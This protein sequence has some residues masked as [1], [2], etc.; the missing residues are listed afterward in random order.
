[1]PLNE[2]ASALEADE[3]LLRLQAGVVLDDE[4]DEPRYTTKSP[5]SNSA[6]QHKSVDYT[7]A[8]DATQLYLNEVGF[9]ALLTPQEEV[10]FA[11]LTQRGDP[12]AR[13]RMIESNLRLVVTIARRYE[14]PRVSW[15]PQLL[16]R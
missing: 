11:R 3:E 15:R 12:A 4:D 7:R 9:A 10:H 8:L 5:R 1:M 2:E 13:K 6:K 14:S 16:R